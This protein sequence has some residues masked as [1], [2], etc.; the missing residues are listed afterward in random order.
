[1]QIAASILTPANN[2]CRSVCV[3]VDVDGTAESYMAPEL[4]SY[5][6]YDGAK[7]D[8]WSCGVVLFN[9]L[10]AH[11]PFQVATYSDWWF[12]ILDDG[13]Y[14][15]FW[16]YVL[17]KKRDY[18]SEDVKAIISR[19]FHTDP[20]TRPSVQDLLQDPWVADN[21]WEDVVALYEA[22]QLAVEGDKKR[23]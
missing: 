3:F 22:K 23:R 4:H 10:T 9:L 18:L 19:I 13:D 20:T 2:W 11:K 21:R 14:Q 17:D 12:E 16:K 8:C 7:A 1:M 15:G 5:R 6:P